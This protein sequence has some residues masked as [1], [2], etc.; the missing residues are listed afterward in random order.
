MQN[1]S[2]Q[3]SIVRTD[4]TLKYY[5]LDEKL[6][7]DPLLKVQ[8][9][10][11]KLFIRSWIEYAQA[12]GKCIIHWS[13]G[14][15]AALVNSIGDRFQTDVQSTEKLLALLTEQGSKRKVI[16]VVDAQQV[17][18]AQLSLL[19]QTL[20]NN[21][22]QSKAD[23]DT[24]YHAKLLLYFNADEISSYQKV[25]SA[26]SQ[27]LYIGAASPVV[28]ARKTSLVTVLLGTLLVAS[29][30][31]AV[32]YWQILRNSDSEFS[33]WIADATFWQLDLD[34]A[35]SASVGIA[36]DGGR[37]S[38]DTT[39]AAEITEQLVSSDS[40]AAMLKTESKAVIKNVEPIVATA[41]EV[42]SVIEKSATENRTVT[43]NPAD[44]ASATLQ[45]AV[46]TNVEQA[47]ELVEDQNQLLSQEGS[48]GIA[49]AKAKA[50]VASID[51]TEEKAVAV[52]LTKGDPLQVKQVI[53]STENQS[54]ATGQGLTATKTKT[55]TDT[56]KQGLT[57]VMVID[58]AVKFSSKNENPTDPIA[59]ST[60]PAAEKDQQ[61]ETQQQLQLLIDAWITAWQQQDF[62]KYSTF[63]GPKFT[64]SKK[65]SHKGWLKW[66]KQRIEKPKWIKLSRSK[67]SFI[68]TGVDEQLSMTFTLNYE[69][70]NYQDETLKKLTLKPVGESYQIIVEQNMQVTRIR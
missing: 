13:E 52:H 46:I 57:A 62:N 27:S 45:S 65:F 18:S 56:S 4:F 1:L 38:A 2:S 41:I 64:V 23:S 16:F 61:L 11:T 12:D 50:K 69:S 14:D 8:G 21:D 43:A 66:R 7:S 49:N 58:T 42:N 68:A 54:Q 29:I 48:T 39:A 34:A 9:P 28:T 26:F 31:S 33:L 51:A 25:L 70:P 22:T 37:S 5:T 24:D 32:G 19:L 10:D 17:P 40:G 67:I 44:K 6:V 59:V 63:Y 60:A 30:L 36:M 20:R 35:K 3:Q 15:F 47:T 53:A 55:N